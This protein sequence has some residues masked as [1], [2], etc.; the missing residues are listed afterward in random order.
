MDERSNGLSGLKA[1]YFQ[2]ILDLSPTVSS[3]SSSSS[4]SS[5]EGCIRRGRG[6]PSTT[7]CC[8]PCQPRME[9][10][11]CPRDD[12]QYPSDKTAR[13]AGPVRPG[14][15]PPND[16]L[17]EEALSILSPGEKN[18]LI[19]H[20]HDKLR[21]LSGLIEEASTASERTVA[22]L[23]RAHR[24]ALRGEML[25]AQRLREELLRWR[26]DHPEVATL[27]EENARLRDENHHSRRQYLAVLEK[28]V[29][30]KKLLKTYL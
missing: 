6:W 29:R 20:M 30:R 14:L 5:S 11:T 26:H 25:S 18:E 3:S 10:C 15:A 1:K 13:R 9:E 17:A 23:E 4:P 7:E 19:L 8:C 27:R 21:H 28:L 2:H 24:D 22:R 12:E 16:A